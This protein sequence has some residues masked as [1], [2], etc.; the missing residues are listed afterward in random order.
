MP[1]LELNLGIPRARHGRD[2]GFTLIEL[3]VVAVIVGVL[4]AIALPS[5]ADYIQ[6]SKIS[7]A[8]SNLSD[9]RTRLEQFYLDNRTYPS[10]PAKC[11]TSGAGAGE[12][13]LPPAQKYF[14][15]ACSAM[16]ATA[17][18]ITA[19]GNA[20]EG[21]STAF[22]YTINQSN[23]RTSAGPAGH[24]TNANCWAVRKNGEC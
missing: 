4:A 21:M 9:M 15:V 1:H 22:K 14:S 5:Y 2:S 20:A 17:Y 24:Y 23:A 7:E 18:T 12:I 16:S 13:N 3:M 8:V 10:G 6:R 11:K 19:T